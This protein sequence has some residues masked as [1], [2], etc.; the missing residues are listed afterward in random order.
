MPGWPPLLGEVLKFSDQGVL[1]GVNTCS[2]LFCAVFGHCFGRAAH[3]PHLPITGRYPHHLLSSI[4]KNL[5]YAFQQAGETELSVYGQNQ[6][7]Y[8]CTT[9]QHRL[10]RIDLV[11]GNAL[12]WYADQLGELYLASHTAGRNPAAEWL[13]IEVQIGAK[14]YFLDFLNSLRVNDQRN[15]LSQVINSRANS[16]VASTSAA[17]PG[18]PLAHVLN[19]SPNITVTGSIPPAVVLPLRAART[20]VNPR[21]RDRSEDADRVI[22]NP[23]ARASN[24]PPAPVVPVSVEPISAERARMNAR[25]AKD[26]ARYRRNHPLRATLPPGPR[27]A[28]YIPV[29]AQPAVPRT[30]VAH[31]SVPLNPI[32]PPTVVPMDNH[33]N[34]AVHSVLAGNPPAGIA[35]PV[36]VHTVPL[37]IPVAAPVPGDVVPVVLPAYAVRVAYAR[38]P[39][40]VRPFPVLLP[41]RVK[42]HNCARMIPGRTMGVPLHDAGLMEFECVHCGALHFKNEKTGKYPLNKG[43]HQ[44]QGQPFYSICCA[45]GKVKLALH[46]DPPQPLRGLLDGS[47]PL[48]AHFLKECRL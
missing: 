28:P 41:G 4:V 11:A 46:Q 24:P 15:A 30:S 32:A 13:A 37:N 43:P 20:Q 27:P 8:I 48:S 36:V 31:A 9:E 2:W 26:R 22:P 45:K 25:N 1:I 23:R 7:S 3:Y 16:N 35:I 40:R 6:A 17:I 5:T 42:T 14:R 21:V 33:A 18:P 44:L 29:M 47:H 38:E 34:A 19:P 10:L 39:R 12:Q